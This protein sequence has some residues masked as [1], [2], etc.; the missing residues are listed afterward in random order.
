MAV[1]FWNR[2][3]MRTSR[4]CVYLHL[5]DP[6]NQ[7]GLQP[8]LTEVRLVDGSDESAQVRFLAVEAITNSRCLPPLR[9]TVNVE[10]RRGPKPELIEFRAKAKAGVRVTSEF[11]FESVAGEDGRCTVVQRAQVFVPRVFPSL[12]RK[13]V[14]AQAKAAQQTLLT[15]LTAR[16]EA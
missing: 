1:E 7:L 10:L 2:C 15:N 9:N 12:M 5:A 6:R 8:L 16:M 11:R 4:E 13:W 14:V 3:E